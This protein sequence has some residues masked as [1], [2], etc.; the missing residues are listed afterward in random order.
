LKRNT[1]AQEC[2]N[3]FSCM[4]EIMLSCI[5]GYCFCDSHR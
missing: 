2:K 3:K 4:T 5:N 1:Y